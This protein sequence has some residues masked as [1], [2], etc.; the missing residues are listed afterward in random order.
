M[1]NQNKSRPPSKSEAI[2]HL[3]QCEARERRH[4]RDQQYSTAHTYPAVDV[5]TGGG[6]QVLAA[7]VTLIA[8]VAHV[9][10]HR[11]EDLVDRVREAGSLYYRRHQQVYS[12]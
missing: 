2:I 5:H 8:A 12:S 11:D 4:E 1:L 6:H 10:G 3:P 7:V 9:A